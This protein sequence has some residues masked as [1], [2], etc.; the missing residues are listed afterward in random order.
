MTEGSWVLVRIKERTPIL[1]QTVPLQFYA[2]LH[3]GKKEALLNNFQLLHFLTYLR[4]YHQTT[5]KIPQMFMQCL[6][7]V[8]C[9]M[10]LWSITSQKRT[11]KRPNNCWANTPTEK[12]GHGD[13]DN[14][15]QHSPCDR[16]SQLTFSPPAV[17][18]DGSGGDSGPRNPRHRRGNFHPQDL[19]AFLWYIGSIK[20]QWV[21]HGIC[22]LREK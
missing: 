18:A 20:G 3:G 1:S 19:L 8:Q 12:P 11:N 22:N 16:Q 15:A 4:G 2:V 17:A 7:D 21:L 9:Y 13:N 14:T 6:E 5:T 10:L